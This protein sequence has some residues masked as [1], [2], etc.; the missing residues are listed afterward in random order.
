[1]A[2]EAEIRAL[3]DR[4][5]ADLDS[6]HDYYS[7]TKIAW[8]LVHKIVASGHRFTVRNPITGTVATQTDLAAK[9]R[10]YVARQLTEATFQHFISTF[11]SFFFDLLRCWLTAYPRSLGGKQID[12]KTVLDAPDKEA[13]TQLVVAKELNEVLYDRPAGWFAYL[14]DRVKLDCPSPVEIER[15]AEAKASRDALVHNQG[16]ASWTYETKAGRL[17][18]FKVGEKVVI[19]EQ[20]HR[21]TWELLRKL[22]SDLSNAAIA[23]AR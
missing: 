19:P 1:M 3:R 8:R 13:V 20:Y 2:L 6:A 11:E 12:F 16:I 23:K 10:A 18:R 4:V 5:L 7:D 17:A 22:V 15:V 9:A 14:Q 21:D